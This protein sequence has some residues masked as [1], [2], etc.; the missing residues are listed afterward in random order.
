MADYLQVE[1]RTIENWMARRYLPFIKIGGTVRFKVYDVL[2]HLENYH[3]IK[4]RLYSASLR[5]MWRP[6]GQREASPLPGEG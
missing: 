5:R 6:T 2:R 1:E 4:P 3:Q